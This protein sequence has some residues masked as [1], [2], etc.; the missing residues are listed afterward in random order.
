MQVGTAVLRDATG[1]YAAARAMLDTSSYTSA[2]GQELLAV[3]AELAACA[4]FIAFDAAEQ[5]TARALLTESALMA[6]SAG[7]PVLAAQAYSLLAL[8]SSSLAP[9]G[10]QVALAREAL[11][12]L[13]M[14]GAAARHV[15]SP[16]V[17]ALI[18]MRRATAS[19]LLGDET[20]MRRFAAAA[21]RELDSGDHPSDPVWAGFVTTAEVNAHEAIARLSLG[22]PARAA[23]AFRAVLSDKALP[24][25]NRVYYHARLAGAL[26]AAGD[27]PQA[28][29]E[30]L[31]ALSGLE[32]PVRSARTLN[33]LRPVRQGISGDSEFAVRFDAVAA[34]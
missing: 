4:G 11:R 25:R 30:G 27:R 23:D 6:S 28:V 1:Y 22:Q 20:E 5:G 29:S 15:P 10:R 9:A 17:H 13:G 26:N 14:A 2:I 16:R 8:Q 34:S 31:R 24:V 18:A 19:A 21:H 7:E 3:T 12:F 33:R 32:G